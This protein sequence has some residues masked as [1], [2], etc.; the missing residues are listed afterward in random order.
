M[1][2][3][4]DIKTLTT[5]QHI[6]ARP[7]M[8]IGGTAP[9]EH[10]MWIYNEDGSIQLSKVTYTEG[11]LKLINEGIDNSV[12]E[13]TKTDGKYATKI[14]VTLTDDTFTIEDNGR[15]IPVKQT[16]T[17]EWMC[18]NA[19]CKPMS[20]SNFDNDSERTSIGV[21]GIG[22]KAANI[23]SKRFECVT[24]DG[25]NRMKIICKENLSSERHTLLA[26]SDRTGT[27]ISFTP[28]FSRFGVEKFTKDI[29]TIVETRLRFLSFFYP[30]CTFNFNGKKVNIRAKELSSMLPSPNVV[31]NDSN[32]Y[33]CVYPSE[34]PRSLSYVNGI[35]LPRGGSHVDYIMNKI[36]SDVR[37]KVSKKYKT[38]KP[39]DIRNR[40]GIVV[41]FKNFTNCA[42]D[43]QTKETLTNSQADVTS[44]LRNNEIDLDR[45]TAKILKENEII[46]NIT[47]L[48]KLKEELAERKALKSANVK[49]KDVDSDKYFP[50]VSGSGKKYLMIT[51]GYSA[52]AGISPI[53][54]RKGIGYYSLK[55]KILNLIGMSP[56]K[57]MQNQ[58]VSDLVNILGIDLEH[59]E[60]TD[61][62]YDYVVVL[63]DADNDGI[64]IASLLCAF[65]NRLCPNLFKEK[66][67]CYLRTPVIIESKGDKVVNYYFDLE[68]YTRSKHD[69]RLTS[70]YVKGL[71]SHTKSQLNQVITKEGGMQ[72]LLQAYTSDSHTSK[73]I[74][75]WMGNNSDFRKNRLKGKEF[76]IDS[77]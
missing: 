16:S 58:E 70:K 51:E 38:I 21:N 68:E 54:G 29:Y 75:D 73:S 53:L 46:D 12:D 31:L 4:R 24:C 19:V 23:Y 18:V 10:D 57:F 35:Y 59:P 40:L 50:P 20:G 69:P 60:S 34:E 41:F 45:F 13:F 1:K 3:N 74:D 71:G 14:S 61:L 52:F 64:H 11:L 63:S 6:L 43:S 5:I 62:N 27:K 39:A 36:I 17:G 9:S 47:E 8:Y 48:Y 25:K 22:I 49:K 33:I 15:G 32:V 7:S 72:N 44:Y 30:K 66:R 2:D 67:F 37:E 56:S 28:D 65:V 77:I 42:F 55:G 26:V 76:H